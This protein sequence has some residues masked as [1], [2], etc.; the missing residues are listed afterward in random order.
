[1]SLSTFIS[2]QVGWRKLLRRYIAA[3][4]G[5]AAAIGASLVA[6]DPYD[7][8]RLSL[9]D[10]YG[11]PQFGQRLTAASLARA[12]DAQAAIIGNSTIQLIDPARLMGLTKLRFI[13]LAIP[14]TGPLEQLTVA[15]WYRRHHPGG[16]E[17]PARAVVFGLDQSWCRGDGRLE[18]TN[19]FPFWLYGDSLADY[20]ANLM[21]IKT[22]EAVARKLKLVI[23]IE[24]PLR[25]D[26]YRDYEIGHP[27][28]AAVREF[29]VPPAD[30]ALPDPIRFSA[31]PR[32]RHFLRE[33]PEATIA[34]LVFVPRHHTLLPPPGSGSE[35]LAS[36][37]KEAFH[38]LA[39][40]RD[41]TILLDLLVD[42]EIAR[43]DR[44]FWDQLHYRRNVAQVI[45]GEIAAALRHAADR[46]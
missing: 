29:A 37:C 8:G 39:A 31:V 38:D 17:S 14:G 13:S 41:R 25:S 3:S 11:V 12:P 42:G 19:P 18:L 15:E 9:F 2:E 7:T 4:I 20:V 43:D 10:G 26:G 36:R 5:L 46:K 6:L 21:R 22:F 45:E 35:R 32:L 30:T 28:D 16:G 44:N 27:R 33:L 40:E 24:R 1:M 23:G 34:V